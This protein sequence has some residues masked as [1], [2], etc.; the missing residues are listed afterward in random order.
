MKKHPKLYKETMTTE[1]VIEA[2]ESINSPIAASKWLKRN[3]IAEYPINSRVSV[4]DRLQVMKCVEGVK[5]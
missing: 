2:V 4:W 5:S 3:R 1:E